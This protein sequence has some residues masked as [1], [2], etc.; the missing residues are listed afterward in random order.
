MKLEPVNQKKKQ[1]SFFLDYQADTLSG[2]SAFFF[3]RIVTIVCSC[4]KNRGH[5]AEQPFPALLCEYLIEGSID[6]LS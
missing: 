1:P 4:E 6:G 3:N 2:V 5:S